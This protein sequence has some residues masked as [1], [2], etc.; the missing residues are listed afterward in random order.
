MILPNGQTAIQAVQGDVT[1]VQK[2]FS[3]LSKGFL[4]LTELFR[5]LIQFQFVFR[6]FLSK[7]TIK[8]FRNLTSFKPTLALHFISSYFFY[9]M[10][11]NGAACFVSP[12]VPTISIIVS[13]MILRLV[14]ACFL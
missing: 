4:L 5:L 1:D 11:M 10:K 12:L 9:L 14:T 13:L 8:S 6:G 2:T 7:F 3:I